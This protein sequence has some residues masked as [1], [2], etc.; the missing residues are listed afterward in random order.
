M[1]LSTYG[2][3]TS[4]LDSILTQQ[5][6]FMHTVDLAAAFSNAMIWVHML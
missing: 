6:F 2:E 5:D 4:D 1:P 3:N